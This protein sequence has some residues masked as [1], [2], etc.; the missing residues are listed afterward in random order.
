MIGTRGSDLALWQANQLKSALEELGQLVELKIIKTKGDK[1]QNLGFD[2]ME[3]KGFFTKEIED[4]LL[5]KETDLAVHSLKDLSTDSPE[6]LIVC[7]LSEREDPTD[8]LII[9]ARSFDKERMLNLKE[10]AILGTSSIRRKVQ[11]NSIIPGIEIRDLRGNVPTRIDKLRQGHFDAII[12]ASAG[13]KR[14]A[15]NLSEFQTVRFNPREFIPAPGQGV[16]AYQCREDDKELRNIVNSIHNRQVNET[17][18]VERKVLKLIG[19][20]CQIPLGVYCEKDKKEN[21]HVYAAYADNML[22]QLKRVNISQSTT[23]NLAEK[24]VKELLS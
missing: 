16:V 9:H 12:I 17:V 10:N 15:L 3:G 8:L 20:G 13:V 5:S 2:K 19:G 7:G 23:L 18:R 4:A 22:T 21:F 6:G 1:I 14:L 24:V 11:I